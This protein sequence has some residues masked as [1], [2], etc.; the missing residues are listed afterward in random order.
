MKTN[1][2]EYAHKEIVCDI[3]TMIAQCE[4][5]A[6]HWKKDEDTSAFYLKKAHLWVLIL[7]QLN[8]NY[9]FGKEEK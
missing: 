8:E 9:D 7:T 4:C 3:K 2:Y 6:E 5:L 1:T